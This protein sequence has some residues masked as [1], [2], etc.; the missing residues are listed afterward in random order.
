MT[1]FDPSRDA[2]LLYGP[3]HETPSNCDTLEEPYPI[4]NCFLEFFSLLVIN[5][6]VRDNNGLFRVK[7]D[8]QMGFSRATLTPSRSS[9]FSSLGDPPYTEADVLAPLMVGPP[10]FHQQLELLN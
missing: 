10:V 5:Q 8:G 6:L 9:H 1:W 4:Q 7:E 2:A 3:L